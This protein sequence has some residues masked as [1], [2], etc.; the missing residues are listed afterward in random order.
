MAGEQLV[1]KMEVKAFKDIKFA[2]A[3]SA[4]IYLNLRFP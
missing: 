1:T 2:L 3:I 4:N